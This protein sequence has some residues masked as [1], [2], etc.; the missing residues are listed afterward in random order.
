VIIAD[1]EKFP[2]RSLYMQYGDWFAGLCLACC[3]AFGVVGWQAQ[4]RA[5][6]NSALPPTPKT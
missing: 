6:V 3:L 4:R 2:Q 5:N 1:V